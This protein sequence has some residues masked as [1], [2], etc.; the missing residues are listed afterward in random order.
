M[1]IP[2][3]E[4]ELPCEPK[5]RSFED[6]SLKSSLSFLRI[7]NEGKCVGS[8]AQGMLRL[9]AADL[10]LNRVKVEGG[11]KILS[12]LWYLLSSGRCLTHHL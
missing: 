8:K 6:L 11:V 2:A 7:R 4:S 12:S 1:R 5:S 10:F 3:N 9:V